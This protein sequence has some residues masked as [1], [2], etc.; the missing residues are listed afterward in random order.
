LKVAFITEDS[1][2]FKSLPRLYAQLR[3]AAPY[4]LLLRPLKVNVPPDAPVATV[5]RACAP[6]ITIARRLG[7]TLIV[8]LLDREHQDDCCGLLA[9]NIEREIRKKV[10]LGDIALRV[11]L[12][13]ATYGKQTS[14]NHCLTHA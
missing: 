11:V 12:S 6:R 2:E 13:A 3:D 7:A 8:V 5:A 4:L 9:D 14:R 1:G 10:D